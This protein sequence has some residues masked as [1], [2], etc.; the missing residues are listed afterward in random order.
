MYGT[1]GQTVLEVLFINVQGKIVLRRVLSGGSC[2]IINVI[3]LLQENIN[4]T[5]YS[6][7]TANS[8]YKFLFPQFSINTHINL[9]LPALIDEGITLVVS[10]LVSLIQDQIMHLLQVIN[11]FKLSFPCTYF[12]ML[13]WLFA[14]YLEQANI[15]AA[16]LSASMEWSEQQEILRGLMSR[17]CTYKL[18]YVTPEKIAK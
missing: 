3:L 9:Q 13:F 1:T 17:T 10:P 14:S 7:L 11:C 18:L 2:E 16:Y 8:I 5:I 15:P 6:R 12:L 4:T